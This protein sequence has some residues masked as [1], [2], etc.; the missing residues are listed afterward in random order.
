[1]CLMAGCG[2]G[3]PDGWVR[4]WCASPSHQAHQTLQG[5]R[6]RAH[7]VKMKDTDM[8]IDEGNPSLSHTHT[9][10]PHKDLNILT[11]HLHMCIQNTTHRKS[12]K[13]KDKDY[14][15]KTE[16]THENQMCGPNIHKE[17]CGVMTLSG[18]HHLWRS[19]SGCFPL[20][21]SRCYIHTHI[22]LC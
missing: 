19:K 7:L 2:C 12:Q 14:L 13:E 1:M 3:V 5:E 4:L 15:H 20:D 18:D 21:N 9:H 22:L 17:V 10:R 11:K 6:V 16:Q 8:D